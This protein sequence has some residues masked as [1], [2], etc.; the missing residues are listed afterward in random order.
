MRRTAELAG[1]RR[2]RAYARLDADLARDAGPLAAYANPTN[3][4]YFSTRMGCQVVQ[5]VYGLDLA[6]LCIKDEADYAAATSP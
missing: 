2:Y 1:P 5:P 6:A 4:Y 3:D